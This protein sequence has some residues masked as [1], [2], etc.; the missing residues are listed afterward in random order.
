MHSLNFMERQKQ[1]ALKVVEKMVSNS[2]PSHVLI[3]ATTISKA[4]DDGRLEI[5]GFGAT[6]A[7]A[8]VVAVAAREEPRDQAE[9]SAR[10][11]QWVAPDSREGAAQQGAG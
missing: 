7:S 5:V 4:V 3:L 10:S 11:G 6:R 2:L 9:E 1:K 8:V